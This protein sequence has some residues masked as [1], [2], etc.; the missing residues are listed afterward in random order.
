MMG[1]NEKKCKGC[2]IPGCGHVIKKELLC[3]YHHKSAT[4]IKTVDGINK[5][6]SFD[7]CQFTSIIYGACRGHALLHSPVKP[8]AVQKHSL[9]PSFTVLIG[10]RKRE[11]ASDFILKSKQRKLQKHKS[12]KISFSLP[13]TQEEISFMV[14]SNDQLTTTFKSPYHMTGESYF[15][16]IQPCKKD[17]VI[18]KLN[19]I[20]TWEKISAD[21]NAETDRIKS[22]QPH[23]YQSILSAACSIFPKS[24]C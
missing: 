1:M 16:T 5:S 3:A 4:Y 9:V 2:L 8:A 11:V 19:N 20:K 21:V 22:N 18:Q 24:D 12:I 23:K 17:L 15:D 10:K 6:C 7:N 13:P 14:R